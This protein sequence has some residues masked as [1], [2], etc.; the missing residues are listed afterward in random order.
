MGQFSFDCTSC[1]GKSQF[2]WTCDAVVALRYP[3][4]K[5]GLVY[6][7]GKYD[8]YG[9][10]H[11]AVV[12]DPTD[13]ID[14]GKWNAA[15]KEV[16]R[17]RKK[18]VVR[19]CLG[20]SKARPAP[21]A[22][23]VESIKPPAKLVVVGDTGLGEYDCR[24]NL[25]HAM[26]LVEVDRLIVGVAGVEYFDRVGK[27]V[28]AEAVYCFG[29]GGV[30]FDALSAEQQKEIKQFLREQQRVQE[31]EQQSTEGTKTLGKVGNDEKENDVNRQAVE[32]DEAITLK[33]VEKAMLDGTRFCVPVGTSVLAC[34][35]QSMVKVILK[36]DREQEEESQIKYEVYEVIRTIVKK[37]LKGDRQKDGTIHSSSEADSDSDSD[38]GSPAQA[39][40][41][42]LANSAE[43]CKGRELDVVEG[44]NDLPP[45]IVAHMP[46]T[47]R[48]SASSFYASDCTIC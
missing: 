43:S 10:V 1:G 48:T 11:I 8:S 39:V 16:I 13:R 47:V 9:R 25:L 2:D 19:S 24:G 26:N 36:A 44:T 38:S 29:D 45:P 4:H 14:G 17:K 6:V 30:T 28:E 37:I 33:N 22:K 40:L 34:L 3:E 41:D 46:P 31:K 35:S 21:L 15:G 20:S 32:G 42:V 7:C 5:S 18:V 12:N 23:Q 27:H